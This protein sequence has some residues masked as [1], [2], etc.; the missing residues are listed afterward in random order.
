MEHRI[1]IAQKGLTLVECLVALAL[2]MIV[3]AVALPSMSRMLDARRLDIAAQK[4]V[5]G[6]WLARSRAVTSGVRVSLC[7]S[8]DSNACRSD[9]RWDLGWLVFVDINADGSRDPGEQ[10]LWTEA[11]IGA[12]WVLRAN[13]NILR[14]IS[15]DADGRS[16]LLSGGFQAGTITI[17]REAAGADGAMVAKVVISATGRPRVETDRQAGVCPLA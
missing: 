16:K 4:T 13:A 10:L 2:L 7:P 15:Y 5:Q 17:C 12:G 14:Y 8:S 1:S 6:L 11:G 9:G 3:S